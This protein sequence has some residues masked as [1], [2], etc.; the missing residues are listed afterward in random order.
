MVLIRSGVNCKRNVKGMA[1][2][3]GIILAIKMQQNDKLFKSEQQ[4]IYS[5]VMA[6]NPLLHSSR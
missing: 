2:E 4:C 1:P 5:G 6:K 3:Y